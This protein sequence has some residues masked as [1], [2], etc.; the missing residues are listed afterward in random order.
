MSD[1]VHLEYERIY[2]REY[3]R[4]TWSLTVSIQIEREHVQCGYVCGYVSDEKVQDLSTISYE[5]G[6]VGNYK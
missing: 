4:C 2:Q 3:E 1:H 5:F 6:F